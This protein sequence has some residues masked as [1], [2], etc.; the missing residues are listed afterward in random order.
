MKKLIRQPLPWSI[1]LILGVQIALALLARATHAA[2]PLPLSGYARPVIEKFL[3]GQTAG[4]QGKV[5]ISIDT[6]LSGNLLPCT[7]LEVFLPSAAPLRGRVSVGVRCLA[8]PRWTRYVQ[9]RIA[10]IGTY[11]AAARPIEAGHILTKADTV[12]LEADMSTLPSSVVTDESQLIG[13]MALT[14]IVAGSALRREQL[15][16]VLMIQQGQTVKVVTRGTGFV[17]SSEGKAMNAGIAGA[18]VQVRMQG[19]QLLSGTITADGI[20]ERGN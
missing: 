12:V 5:Q 1:A 20:V 15:R 6:P 18:L 19:G 3:A 2:G 13:Q 9:A 4:L 8:E 7:V 11:Q 17:V 14:R 16:G 10:V